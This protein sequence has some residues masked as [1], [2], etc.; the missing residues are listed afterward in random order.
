MHAPIPKA[1]RN[2]PHTIGRQ[3]EWNMEQSQPMEEEQNGTQELHPS[4]L[5]Y[6]KMYM[7]NMYLC[8][9]FRLNFRNLEHIA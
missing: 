1:T 5:H 8:F 9:V 3:M 2:S 4:T 6:G 7:P